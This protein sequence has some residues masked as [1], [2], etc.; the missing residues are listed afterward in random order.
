M[1]IATL[2]LGPVVRRH[3]FAALAERSSVVVDAIKKYE[4]QAGVP[5]ATLAALVPDYLPSYPSTGMTAYPAY[6]Y[7]PNPT[8]KRLA[9]RWDLYVD[10]SSGFLNYDRF[11]YSP[12]TG[13]E[14]TGKP[15]QDDEE[16]G[17]PTDR[18]GDWIYEHD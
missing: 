6:I 8:P 4:R 3:A 12:L 15:M 18:Y 9:M 17:K 2:F 16:K 7:V 10:C 5:P 13:I 11:M 14:W 1:G